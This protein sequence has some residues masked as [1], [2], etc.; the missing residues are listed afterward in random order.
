MQQRNLLRN[1]AWVLRRRRRCGHA[2]AARRQQRQK[3]RVAARPHGRSTAMPLGAHAGAQDA[4]ARVS[5]RRLSTC[6][7]HAAQL[8]AADE[9]LSR[10][11]A[12][13]PCHVLMALRCDYKDICR[14][15]ARGSRDAHEEKRQQRGAGGCQAACLHCGSPLRRVLTAAG[16]PQRWNGTVSRCL[17]AY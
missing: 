12:A 17:T 7:L 5:Q 15:G 13:Q 10:Q 3:Q 6:A 11:R 16:S 2:N 8:D 1:A 9:L 4:A 14:E